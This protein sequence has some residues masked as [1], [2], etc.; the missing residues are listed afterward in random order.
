MREARYR[1]KRSATFLSSL[2][3]DFIEESLE[4]D[5]GVSPKRFLSSLAQDFI[6][7]YEQAAVGLVKARN[8]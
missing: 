6:E 4:T 7:D 2:A 1:R 3:Q 8:S 5:P